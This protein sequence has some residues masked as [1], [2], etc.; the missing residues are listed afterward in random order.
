MT[1]QLYTQPGNPYANDRDKVFGEGRVCFDRGY[2]RQLPGW[3]LP[4][5]GR[6][7]CEMTALNVAIAIDRLI[8]ANTRAASMDGLIKQSEAARF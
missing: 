2:G 8:R 4:G 1:E 3:A 7:S 6:T 5:G